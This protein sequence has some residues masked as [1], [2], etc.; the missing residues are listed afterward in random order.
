MTSGIVKTLSALALVLSSTPLWAGC[1][2][3][4][5]RNIRLSNGGLLTHTRGNLFRASGLDSDTYAVNWR[6]ERYVLMRVSYDHF[7]CLD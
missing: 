4:N 7:Q 6:A 5:G 2:E 1:S 3:L